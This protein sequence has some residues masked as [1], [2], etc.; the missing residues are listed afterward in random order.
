MFKKLLYKTLKESGEYALRKQDSAHGFE[1]EDDSVV[2]EVDLFLSK[3]IK[4]EIIRFSDLHDLNY[5]IIDEESANSFDEY[6]SKEFS[7]II[8]PIDGTMNYSNGHALW[9]ISIGV[10]RN[11]QP[12]AGGVFLP[13]INKMLIVDNNKIYVNSENGL[14]EV[15]ITKKKYHGKNKTIAITNGALYYYNI[16]TPFIA[17]E[18]CT[19]SHMY[20][21]NT[22]T[23]LGSIQRVKLWDTAASLAIGKI[24]GNYGWTLKGNKM[25]TFDEKLLNS[26]FSHKEVFVFSSE[27]FKDEILNTLSMK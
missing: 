24:L 21:T 4:E 17:S 1:K 19:V 26:D 6:L 10:F 25:E 5:A 3:R 9:A 16:E 14:E 23:H 2:T 15:D 22:G 20:F 8:D 13:A 7:F 11:Q 12:Y 18:N 27:E